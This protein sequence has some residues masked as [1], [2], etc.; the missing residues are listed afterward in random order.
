MVT[1]AE[2]KR[3]RKRFFDIHD[4]DEY[5]CPDCERTQGEHGRRWEVHHIDGEAGKCVGLCRSCHRI[6]HGATRRSVDVELWKRDVRGD[7]GID[8]EEA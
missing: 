1:P 3:D 6:R 7:F 2:R 8:A 4:P 5:V